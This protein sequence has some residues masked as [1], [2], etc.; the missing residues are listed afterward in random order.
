[1]IAL[2]TRCKNEPYVGEFVNYYLNQ[3]IDHIYILDDMSEEGTFD[4]VLNHKQV[5]IRQHKITTWN[6][7]F[8]GCK[9]MYKE[10][11]DDYEWVIV[12]DMDEYITTV[13]NPDSTIKEELNTTFKDCDCINI[14]W[15]MM[16]CN[17]IEKNPECLLET[18]FYRWD[19]DK[20]H[21]HN[22][23]KFRCRYDSI[24]TKYICRTN[25]YISIGIHSPCGGKKKDLNIYTSVHKKKD[26]G[27][28]SYTSLREKDIKVAHMICYHY[29]IISVEGCRDKIKSNKH[30]NHYSLKDLLKTDHPEIKDELMRNKSLKQKNLLI[31]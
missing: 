16:S 12:V 19:H 26:N 18:N 17:S 28:G 14:P 15:V 13:K 3:G 5:T 11:Q 6:E 27:Y 23:Q 25:K 1:M 7:Q 30:Y 21:E 24:E 20:K 31:N 22:Q 9:Q 10:I 29:R 4:K 8:L 2:I